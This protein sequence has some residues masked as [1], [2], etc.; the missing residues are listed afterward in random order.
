MN[1]KIDICYESDLDI[2]PELVS[3]LLAKMHKLFKDPMKKYDI[4]IN[5]SIE[6]KE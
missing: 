1:E 2:D 4:N 6:E 3:T 5:I